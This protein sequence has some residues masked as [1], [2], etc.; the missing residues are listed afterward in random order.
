[1]SAWT[2]R[3]T[4]VNK[5]A[6]L[7][8]RLNIPSGQ[9]AVFGSGL[10]DVLGLRQSRDIDL[11]V[12]R[13]LFEKLLQRGDWTEIAYPDGLSGL[14]HRSEDVEAFYEAG[15]SGC[16][17]AG[18]RQKIRQADV[19]DGVSFVNLEDIL[20]WK[21]EMGRPKDLKDVELLEKY[22]VYKC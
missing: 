20:A 10:L 3:D 11:L 19:I 6:E 13:E 12:S 17:E 2:M 9:Y 18:V 4:G 1:M 15:W 7:V 14:K 5:Y 21:R 8:E 16:D 22:K